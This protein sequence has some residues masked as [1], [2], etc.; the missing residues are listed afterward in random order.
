MARRSC[1]TITAEKL[2]ITY[3][4]GGARI[5]SQDGAVVKITP[6]GEVQCLISIGEHGQG[7]E[8]IIGQIV[9]ETLG[10][11]R[12]TVRVITGD[13]DVTPYGGANWACRG[14]GIGGETALQA[15]KKLKANVLAMRLSRE[16]AAVLVSLPAEAL[17]RRMFLLMRDL[18]TRLARERPT[19]SA[20]RRG[21]GSGR[22]RERRRLTRTP[23]AR[24]C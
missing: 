23:E 5:S 11:E 2:K 14:A 20:T 10:V 17:R 8:T 22:F 24:R 7:T 19:D 1:S 12:E 21:A 6:S 15:A 9:A 18:F 13:T 3:G 4:V 16:E